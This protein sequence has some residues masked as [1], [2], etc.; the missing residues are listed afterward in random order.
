MIIRY[1][2]LYQVHKTLVLTLE[3]FFVKVDKTNTI[4]QKTNNTLKVNYMKM[5][6]SDSINSQLHN[7][8]MA[9]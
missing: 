4:L 3:E 2:L 6:L 1:L 9:R 7:A 8:T 5:Y